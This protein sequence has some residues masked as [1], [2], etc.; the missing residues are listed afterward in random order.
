M[1][2]ES[3]ASRLVYSGDQVAEA[4]QSG[5]LEEQMAMDASA[6]Q[7]GRADDVTGG[8]A[9]GQGGGHAS[10]LG[11]LVKSSGIYAVASIAAPFVSLILAP[12][13]TSR[14]TPTDYGALA[15]TNTAISL[16]IAISQLGLGSAFFR[17]YNFDATTEHEKQKVLATVVTLLLL[18]S[19]STNVII[20]VGASPLA[21]ALLG[22][23]SYAPLIRLAAWSIFAQNLSVPAFAW[24][25]AE[26]RALPFSL[27]AVVNLSV[28][29][30]GTI[31]LV[32]VVQM[33]VAGALLATAAGYA[34]VAALSLPVILARAGLSLRQD[35]IWN[36]LAF[37][38]P[39]VFSFMSGWVLQISDR[40]LLSRM[41]SLSE[42]AHYSIAYSLG[43]VLGTLVVTP[44][45]LA[46]PTAMYAIAKRGDAGR[47]FRLVF[48]AFGTVLLLAAFGLTVLSTLMLNWF[49]PPSYRTAA[50]VIPL[51]ALS[52]ALY[53]MYTVYMTGAN[54]R[55][56][57]WL[58]AI[59][60][61]A[62]AVLNIALN[63]VLIPRYGAMGAAIST[64][65]A[66][67]L[68]ALVTL[69]VNQRIYPVP[70]GPWR[71]VAAL[72]GVVAIY[73]LGAVAGASAGVLRVPISVLALLVAAGW[74]FIAGNGR[75]AL[76]YWRGQRRSAASSARS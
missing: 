15:V 7:D 29:L 53:G 5:T 12:F 34:T 1:P 4:A 42:A 36:L 37:G 43:G 33:G 17:A 57:T 44:F 61:T 58:G 13:L 21:V 48:D 16:G 20:T 68:L 24:M 30:V 2:S 38:V 14:L 35:I 45:A 31:L 40:Y 8:Q 63:L 65:L 47:V 59:Y 28:N 55:R 32:G 9:A 19:L 74:L 64:L 52:L 39:Q 54:I 62:A 73:T 10:L 6:A 69:V 25:R 51:V 22:S 50:P 11:S 60:V 23:S 66:Y 46:W 26:N 18:L 70:Y 76:R 3:Q 67:V 41:V 49:F 72:G 56:M 75:E 27:L 71:F